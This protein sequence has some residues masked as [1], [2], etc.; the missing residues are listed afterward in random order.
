MATILG[1]NAG[2][3]SNGTGVDDIIIAGNDNDATN[4]GADILSGSNGITGWMP[5]KTSRLSR[6]R[7]AS[8][9][10]S[11]SLPASIADFPTMTCLM[12]P[13]PARP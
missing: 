8:I 6:S 1:T 7:T 9:G 13:L 2:S 10:W 5:G 3:S 11:N 4:G 12:H